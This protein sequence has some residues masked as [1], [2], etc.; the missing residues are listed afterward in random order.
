M[1]F[2]VD[3]ETGALIQENEIKNKKNQNKNNFDIDKNL[4]STSFDETNIDV[5]DFYEELSKKNKEGTPIS[6]LDE[7]FLDP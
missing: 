5:G 2:V 4:Y 7:F 3:P 6:T 1:A